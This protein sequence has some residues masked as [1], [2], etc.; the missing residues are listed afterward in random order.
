MKKDHTNCEHSQSSA[1]SHTSSKWKVTYVGSSRAFGGGI[2]DENDQQVA[3]V[4]VIPN[5]D[6]EVKRK[7]NAHLIAAAPS[8]L[9]A[10]KAMQEYLKVAKRA[11]R[12]LG[13]YWQ[14]NTKKTLEL[15]SAAINAAQGN[16]G[17]GALK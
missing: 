11:G 4:T 5:D 8:L 9:E 13:T 2:A 3:L 1:H 17:S 14:D 10:C 12:G 16:S 6:G 7:Q 15:A